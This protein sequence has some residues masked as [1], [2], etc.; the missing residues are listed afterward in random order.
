MLA[1]GGGALP[2]AWLIIGGLQRARFDARCLLPSKTEPNLEKLRNL[3][4]ENPWIWLILIFTRAGCG[5]EDS[6]LPPIFY[7]HIA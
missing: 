1:F 4:K 5:N 3:K 6:I 7:S 2:L